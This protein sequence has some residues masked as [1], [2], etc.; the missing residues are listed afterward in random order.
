MK[1]NGTKVDGIRAN[2]D[3]NI[4]E[5]AKVNAIG[6]VS[7]VTEPEYSGRIYTAETGE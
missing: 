1:E 2:G 5:A 4:A 7:A 6:N 3:V